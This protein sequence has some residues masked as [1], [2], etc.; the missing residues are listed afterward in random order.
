MKIGFTGSRS[1]KRLTEDM[2]KVLNKIEK[3]DIVIHGGAI[4]A[5]KLIKEWCDSNHITQEII[6]PINPSEK[7]HY[8]YRN[9]EIV[10]R[11]SKLIVFWNG[12]SRGTQFTMNYAQK[13]NKEIILVRLNKND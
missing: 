8:L 3:N 1:I 2:I 12:S 10:T 7:V 4:G 11:C 6:K 13:R 5:D 9:V